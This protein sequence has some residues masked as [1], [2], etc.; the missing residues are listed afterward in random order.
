M[1]LAGILLSFPM[2]LVI[3]R[4]VE[5][6]YIVQYTGVL[7]LA[8]IE[9]EGV[10]SEELNLSHRIIL[11][12]KDNAFEN[13][14]HI[15][16]LNLS[17]NYLT[18]LRP[19]P[20]ASL[21][22]LEYLDLSRNV[23]SNMTRPFA[24]LSNLKHLDLSYNTIKK[25]EADHFFGLKKS[26]HIL[27]KDNK[28]SVSSDEDL[29]NKYNFILQTK[30]IHHKREV[31]STIDPFVKS[32][33]DAGELISV[34]HHDRYTSVE[35][36]GPCIVRPFPADGSLRLNSLDIVEFQEGWFQ[37][38]SSSN[39]H[40][41]DLRDN[42]ISRLTSEMFNDIPESVRS[43][44]LGYNRIVRL[45]KDIIVNRHLRKM[46][47]MENGI[48]TIEDNTFINTNLTT[49]NFLGNKIEDMKFVDTLPWTIT[50]IFMCHNKVDNLFPEFWT[51]ERNKTRRQTISYHNIEVYLQCVD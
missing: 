39:I 5:S 2:I 23:I 45:E 42:Y 27:L 41:I 9:I 50:E 11:D 24:H 12:I 43:V 48:K 47:F 30:K 19:S 26:C 1:F 22:N 34:E 29:G 16:S 20:F 21:T 31:S 37:L 33:V 7:M 17:N 3:A 13:V 44:N 36:T 35:H 40:T 51:E 4:G 32:C 6:G 15:K 46:Y 49:L 28:I 10:P 25:L 38:R 18:E 8:S 14:S